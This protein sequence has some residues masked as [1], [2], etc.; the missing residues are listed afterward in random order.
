MMTEEQLCR[1]VDAF[2]QSDHLREINTSLKIL[3]EKAEQV[4]QSSL[5]THAI[6]LLQEENARLNLAYYALMAEH[7]ELKFRL[8]ETAIRK[9]HDPAFATSIPV[10]PGENQAS[11]SGVPQPASGAEEVATRGAG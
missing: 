7:T 5:E 11:G 8:M 6:R 3:V 4:F 2:D 9:Q 10:N 1:L